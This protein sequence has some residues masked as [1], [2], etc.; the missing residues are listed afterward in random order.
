MVPFLPPF[1]YLTSPLRHD[2]FLICLTPQLFQF[3]GVLENSGFG[4]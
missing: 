4:R 2:L 3:I 1:R